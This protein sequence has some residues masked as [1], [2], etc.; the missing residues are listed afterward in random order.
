MD[1]AKHEPRFTSQ[2][3]NI[4]PPQPLNAHMPMNNIQGQ[5]VAQQ[6][7]HAVPPQNHLSKYYRPQNSRMSYP[8]QCFN[9]ATANMQAP[10]PQFLMY[11][12]VCIFFFTTFSIMVTL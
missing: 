9:S 7:Q 12:F 6:P 1:N 5:P 8:R 2:A 4:I 3:E 10:P 11:S